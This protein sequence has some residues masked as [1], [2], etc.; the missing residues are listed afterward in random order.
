MMG[1]GG[2]KIPWHPYG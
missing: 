2:R 1:K